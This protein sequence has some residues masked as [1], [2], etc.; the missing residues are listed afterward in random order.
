ME[1]FGDETERIT[2]VDPLT[3]EIL[4]QL[5]K[6]KDLF[7]GSHYVTPQEEAESR[8]RQDRTGA[9]AATGFVLR[10]RGSCW[11]RSGW[12]SARVLTWKCS[13]RRGL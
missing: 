13:K 5:Q 6:L 2:K 12:S 4:K 3:G 10:G 7:P 9:R 8:P 1:F 11:K